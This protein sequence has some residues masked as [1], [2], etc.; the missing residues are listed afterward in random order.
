MAASQRTKN[1]PRASRGEVFQTL[2][3]PGEMD[4][5]VKLAI[6]YYN[7]DNPEQKHIDLKAV[8]NN[9]TS[10]LM[11]TLVSCLLK[12]LDDSFDPEVCIKDR[13]F[14]HN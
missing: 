5:Y 2:W 3:A 8:N 9:L 13:R 14:N 1:A 10:S 6:Q 7:Q 12:E 11:C 4:S